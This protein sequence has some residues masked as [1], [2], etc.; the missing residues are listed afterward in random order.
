MSILKIE[1]DD[2]CKLEPKD[3]EELV[4]RLC[5]AEL[6]AHGSKRRYVHGPGTMAAPDG[7]VD[8][9]VDTEGESFE[10]DFIPKEKTIF[11][12]KTST[13]SPAKIKKEVEK[14]S[15][16]GEIKSGKC[17]YIIVGIGDNNAHPEY[18]KKISAIK[19]V[20][21]NDNVRVGFY[22]RARLN[23]WLCQYLS[24]VYWVR[25]KINKPLDGWKDLSCWTNIHDDDRGKSG[26][27][28]EEGAKVLLP[29]KDEKL[30]FADAI[31]IVREHLKNSDKKAVRII[32]MSGVGKTRFVQA[33][34][35]DNK[36]DEVFNQNNVIYADAGENLNP[37]PTTLLD[38][39]ITR[40]CRKVLVI[41]NCPSEI[42]SNL[43]SKLRNKNDTSIRLITIEFDIRDDNPQSTEVI[44]IEADGVKVAEKLIQRRFPNI[45]SPSA[46]HIAQNAEGN[47]RLAL[48]LAEAFKDGGD[49]T[50]LSDIELFDRLFYQRGDKNE[51]L[52]KQAEVLSLVYSFSVEAHEGE[53]DELGLLAEL[54]G[55]RHEDMY[56][57]VN[58]FV[59]KGI[60]QQRGQWRAILPHP[61]AN[62]LAREAL[63]NIPK[64]QIQALFER[65]G[66][67]RLLRSFAKRLGYMGKS[68]TTQEI[69]KD[70]LREEGFLGKH[71]FS[72]GSIDSL[73]FH[74]TQYTELFELI[75]PADP[76][77]ALST[78]KEIHQKTP[79]NFHFVPLLKKI[80]YDPDL[81]DDAI[82]QLSNMD[83]KLLS[84]T[85][86]PSFF[87]FDLSGTRA[88]LQQRKTVVENLLTSDDEAQIELGFLCLDKSLETS[89]QAENFSSEFGTELRNYGLNPTWEKVIEWFSDF[90]EIARNLALGNNLEKQ[91]KARSL[92][93]KHFSS[94]WKI[95]RLEE[96]M[97]RTF[98]ELHRQKTWIEGWIATKKCLF[99]DKNNMSDAQYKKL[100]KL[101]NKT[102]PQNLEDKIRLWVMCREVA[103]RPD[104][105]M[106]EI[107]L[108][109]IGNNYQKQ[110]ESLQRNAMNLGRECANNSEV[111]SRITPN[112]F[113]VEEPRDMIGNFRTDFG[114]GLAENSDNPEAVWNVLLE[115]FRERDDK[116]SFNVDVLTGLLLGL[117][118]KDKVLRAQLLDQCLDEPYLSKTIV[119]LHSSKN[120]SQKDF[121]RCM[122]AFDRYGLDCLGIDRLIWGP[123]YESVPE[124]KKITLCRKI[125]EKNGIAVCLEALSMKLHVAKDTLENLPS[126]YRN[127]G[128]E[129]ISA[130]ILDDN[131]NIDNI[132][133]QAKQI[134]DFCFENEALEKEKEHLFQVIVQKLKNSDRLSLTEHISIILPFFSKH[135]KDHF[136]REIVMHFPIESQTWRNPFVNR[137]GECFLKD[138]TPEYIVEWCT[139]SQND[140]SWIRFA[141]AIQ[142]FS[143]DNI[144]KSCVSPQANAILEYAPNP[145]TILDAF[146]RQLRPNSWSNNASP[147]IEQNIE[148]IKALL[149]HSNSKVHNAIKAFLPKAQEYLNQVIQREQESFDQKKGFEY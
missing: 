103:H 49:A 15:L 77:L 120:F 7:G 69:V 124:E 27:I 88:S 85:T 23:Q 125:L 109:P 1:P 37:P 92:L 148:A 30:S 127:L 65:E 71:L 3:A 140:E 57:A 52:K 75:A 39:L 105:F 74:Q 142:V 138:F 89:P 2:L 137:M 5:E 82:E 28:L 147:Y 104:V 33:L 139:Q 93:A 12:V 135:M 58:T 9:M 29:N 42:H 131:L 144:G 122:L 6:C 84:N 113:D 129:T 20:T 68:Q 117:S 73:S 53:V 66:G 67:H 128:L 94:L 21:G 119:W 101:C 108:E 133:H 132:S 4:K 145:E 54:C 134:L 76:K 96:T 143:H 98:I 35:E 62:R 41:D 112:L 146:F 10:G 59:K 107:E 136:V 102:K 114:Q 32:G 79:L 13:M 38:L 78:I 14:C 48:A 40:K 43:T 26:L 50:K 115:T 116:N 149:P 87:Q 130:I 11:Q 86:I 8:V 99:Y 126:E 80:A 51:T 55:Q 44:R 61:I 100:R 25:E 110:I 106:D 16:L 56:R 121:D 45:D 31:P 95:E 63:E 47:A 60:A 17:A 70:W 46:E 83:I 18:E 91:K 118:K 24:V 72:H 34:F 36:D 111:F 64:Q 97:E 141:R 19:N 22:D 123:G 90:I 81:F